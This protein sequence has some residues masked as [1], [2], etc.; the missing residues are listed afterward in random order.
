MPLLQFTEKHHYS[1]QTA[2]SSQQE[3]TDNEK[4]FCFLENRTSSDC[5][6]IREI[7]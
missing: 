6:C 5:K 3:E 4:W 1:E 7:F 2:L